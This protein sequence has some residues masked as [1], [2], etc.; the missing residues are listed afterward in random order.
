MDQTEGNEKLFTY[1]KS[2]RTWKNVLRN[3]QI[4][5]LNG[6]KINTYAVTVS[7]WSL[8]QIELSSGI[9]N[10][11]LVKL[12]GTRE[13]TKIMDR[14]IGNNTFKVLETDDDIDKNVPVRL[15]S[16][17]MEE[18]DVHRL[19]R[20]LIWMNA[21]RIC[22]ETGEIPSLSDS[23]LTV[24]NDLM[25]P[26][27]FM[28]DYMMKLVESGVSELTS[29]T[30]HNIQGEDGL[31]FV[32]CGFDQNKKAY[33]VSLIPS[34][35]FSNHNLP[36]LYQK[37]LAKVKELFSEISKTEEFNNLTVSR[38]LRALIYQV[39]RNNRRELTGFL[40]KG[41][42]M[43][44]LKSLDL[45]DETTDKPALKTEVDLKELLSLYNHYRTEAEKLSRTWLQTKVLF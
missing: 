1:L 17:F 45:V 13:K 20:F 19:I 14:E 8:N 18:M 22:D 7:P 36:G 38:T 27:D 41:E 10:D 43:T 44:I 26:D 29:D 32:V 11:E 21:G 24:K 4:P 16:E 9:K 5:V 31:L 42:K 35:A 39:E 30:L 6:E 40:W 12:I 25:V 34:A 15:L 28:P 37:C 3:L 23:I 33:P 2:S